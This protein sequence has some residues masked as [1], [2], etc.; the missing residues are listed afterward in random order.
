MYKLYHYSL[1][2]FSRTIRFIL[3]ELQLEYVLLEEKFWEYNEQFL[4]INPAGSVPVMITKS[5]DILNHSY[6]IIDYIKS[7]YNTEFLFP[8]ENNALEIKKIFLWFS[9]KF[10]IDC[11]KFF[12]NE[13]AVKYFHEKAQPNTNTLGMARYNL[14]IHFDYLNYLLE[15]NTWLAGEKFSLADISA[16]CQIS[17]LDFLGEIQWSKI[18]QIKDWYSIIK[19][20]PSFR[21]FLKERIPGILTPQHYSNLDF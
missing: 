6:L 7:N 18:P 12:I 21:S 17:V 10:F 14:N 3:N 15:Q 20:K 5:G 8:T 11:T 2:P 4:Q 13:K 9:E 16:A 1:C 19:S